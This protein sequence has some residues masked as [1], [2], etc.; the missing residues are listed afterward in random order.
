MNHQPGDLRVQVPSNASSVSKIIASQLTHSFH[1]GV[2]RAGRLQD[3]A[4]I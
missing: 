1:M 4:K 3:G 2:D